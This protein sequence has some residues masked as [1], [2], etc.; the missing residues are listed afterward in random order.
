MIFQI[1]KL[2]EDV[3]CIEKINAV[4]WSLIISS[5]SKEAMRLIHRFKRCVKAR[6]ATVESLVMMSNAIDG[7]NWSS[8]TGSITFT[9]ISLIG[10][11]TVHAYLVMASQAKL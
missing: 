7:I 10:K 4:D 8:K 9:V 1:K 11:P 6:K 5:E 3:A 2:R